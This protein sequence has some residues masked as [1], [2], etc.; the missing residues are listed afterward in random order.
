MGLMRIE[1]SGAHVTLT[2]RHTLGRSPACASVVPDPRVSSEH[3]VLA[4]RGDHWTLRDLGSRNGTW[5]EGQPVP[6]GVEVPVRQGMRLVLGDDAGFVL[7]HDGA[8]VAT[9]RAI[10]AEVVVVSSGDVLLLPDDL[11]PLAAVFQT[12]DGAWVLEDDSPRPVADLDLVLIGGARWRLYL[13]TVIAPTVA[14]QPPIALTF[15]VSPDE[16]HVTVHVAHGGRT[17]TLPPRSHHYLLLTLARLR[18]SEVHLPPSERG[19]VTRHALARA[20]RC[21]PATVNVQLHRLRQDLG[22]HEIVGATSLLESRARTG[23]VRIGAEHL[24]VRRSAADPNA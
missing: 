17:T 22:R 16:E 23:Q 12:A 24:A 1:A 13:P 11:A 20:L 8:P 3:A 4:W 2:A 9:A 19:W 21:D 6:A 7:D 18:T 5:L 10:D 15:D 14:T